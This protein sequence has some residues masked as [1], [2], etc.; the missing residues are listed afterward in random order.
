MKS[1]FINLVVAACTLHE[2]FAFSTLPSSK[3]H[4]STTS[5]SSATVGSSNSR[6]SNDNVATMPSRSLTVAEINEMDT[7]RGE[8]IEKYIAL[9]HTEEVSAYYHCYIMFLFLHWPQ[10][11]INLCLLIMISMPP[12]KLGIF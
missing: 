5:L 10:S 7:I 6:S 3:Q 9:G 11:L 12:E 8:L 1:F 2:G 4:Y